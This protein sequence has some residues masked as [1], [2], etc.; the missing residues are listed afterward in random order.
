MTG[1]EPI[2]AAKFNS[3]RIIAVQKSEIHILDIEGYKTLFSI[4]L[5]ISPSVLDSN[6]VSF[7]NSKEEDRCY[8]VYSDSHTEG[9]CMV[10]DAFNLTPVS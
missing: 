10:Y 2:L 9:I 5:G 4:S 1:G 6:T 8:L 7:S 3:H